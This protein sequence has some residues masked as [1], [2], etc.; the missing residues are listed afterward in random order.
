[1]MAD[2]EVLKSEINKIFDAQDTASLKT[3]SSGFKERKK[4]LEALQQY[5]ISHQAE[6]IEALFTDLRKP[7]HETM[8]S[9]IVPVLS[10]IR[11]VG[12]NLNRWMQPVQVPTPLSGMGTTSH[13]YYEAKG[14]AL[15][16]APWNYPFSLVMRPLIYAIAAGCTAIIKPSEYAPATSKLISQIINHL[17]DPSE[18]T[19]VEGESDV[20]QLL[21]A[22]PFNHIYFTGSPAVGKLVMKAAA[23]N[24]TSVTLEL[25]GKSPLIID[26]TVNLDKAAD[27]IIWAKFLNN[28]QTCI[29][30]DYILVHASKKDQLVDSLIN[31]IQKMYN[32]DQN[33]IQ[34]SGSY[35][36]IINQKNFNRLKQLLNDA[37]GN[38]AIL[39]FGGQLAEEDL[40]FEPTILTQVN[41][42]M[43]V[44]QEEI[45]GPILPVLAFTQ[46]EEAVQ[47]IQA[48]PK[49]LAFYIMSEKADVQEMLIKKI[50]A[51]GILVNDFL[52]HFANPEL[53]FG[54]INNSGI[55]KSNGFYGF[56]EFSNA[57]GVMKRRLG[58]IRFLYPPY[59]KTGI[60]GKILQWLVRYF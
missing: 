25:G 39:A 23:E 20:S 41:H 12:K 29:A 15:I 6:V 18:V 38:G 51:G 14:K 1:M 36:R 42:R 11:Y 19:V 10:E 17:F 30:P 8:L 35:G 54:G 43:L 58:D 46:L 55:G 24:L 59:K 52:Q 7:E 56:Q 5:L 16:I 2:N 48:K 50:S 28:G 32:S 44:M 47:M 40:Y 13:I 21:L 27:K 53:P 3:A 22:Q 60:Q 49:P 57:K 37:V 9:E 33:G 26:E 31:S 34:H 4:K 45:F